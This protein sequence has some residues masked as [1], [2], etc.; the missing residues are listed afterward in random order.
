MTFQ[1]ATA[2]PRKGAS[3][4]RPLL[5]RIRILYAAIKSRRA[6]YL[7]ERS[8]QRSRRI[9]EALPG[10]ILS[11]IGWPNINDRLPSPALQDWRTKPAGREG[12]TT[13]APAISRH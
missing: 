9:L 2:L 11:D 7:H 8:L 10:H 6:A 3:V 12:K 13:V 4:H 1:R 5:E